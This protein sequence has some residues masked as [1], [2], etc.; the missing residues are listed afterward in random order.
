MKNR[1]F[2]VCSLIIILFATSFVRAESNNGIFNKVKSP[3]NGKWIIAMDKNSDGGIKIVFTDDGGKNYKTIDDRDGISE[4]TQ[5]EWSPGGKYVLIVQPMNEEDDGVLFKKEK[6]YWHAYASLYSPA[7]NISSD[8]A[9][10]E[11]KN[12]YN[13][14]YFKWEKGNVISVKSWNSDKQAERAFDADIDK[15]F[16]TKKDAKNVP[17]NHKP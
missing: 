11:S 5:F 9:G 6:G 10:L 16:T 12:G 14:I 2:C 4:K 7:R 1:L 3:K 15:L 17:G 8:G 13:A